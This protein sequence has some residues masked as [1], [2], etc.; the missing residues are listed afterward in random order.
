MVVGREKSLARAVDLVQSGICV[1]IV[2]SRGSGRTTF[3]SALRKRLED[4]EWSV[5]SVRGVASLRQHSLAALHLAGIGS[6]ARS[7][8]VLHETA[9]A[10]RAAVQRENSVVFLDD[11]DDLDESSWGIVESIRRETGVP[12]VLT[13]LQGLR[14]RHTPSGLTAS[15]LEPSYVI[16]M[17]PLRFDDMESALTSYLGG[18]IEAS[19]ISRIF[20]KSGGNIGLAISLVDATTREGLLK[21]RGDRGEWTAARDLWSPGLR[22]VLEGYLENLDAA[23]RDAVE[24]IA[25]VGVAGIESVRQLVD[26]STLELLEERSL[27]AFVSGGPQQLVTVVPPLLVEF[28]R[29]EPLNARRVRLTQL[30][31]DRLGTEESMTA[32]LA[33]QQPVPTLAPEGEAMFVRLLHERARARRIVTASEWHASPSPG[34]AIRYISAL[35]TG[36][37]HTNAANVERVF[38]GT[39]LGG[40][41]P[42]DLVAF[43]ALR[44]RWVAYTHNDH[45]AAL[46]ILRDGRQQHLGRYERLLDATEVEI[47][48]TL[49]AIP[50]GFEERLEVT[51]D[52]P[53][54]VRAALLETQL[55]ILVESARFRDAKRIFRQ[56]QDTDS[57]DPSN[58]AQ[59]LYAFALLGSGRADEALQLLLQGLDEAQGYL[60]IEAI[61]LFG[62]AVTLC[63]AHSGDHASIDDLLET[64]FSAGDPTPIPVGIQLT[65]LGVA[66]LLAARRGHIALSERFADE[67]TQIAAPDG[68]LPGQSRAWATVP[69]ATFNGKP[70]TAA[71]VLWNASV[72][73]WNRGAR[74]A[75]MVGLLNS[76]EIHPTNERFDAARAYLEEIPEAVACRAHFAYVAALREPDAAALLRAALELERV[77]CIG[78]ALAACQQALTSARAGTDDPIAAEATRLDT[79]IRA[80]NEPGSYDSVRFGATS[81]ILSDRES[82]VARLA[83]DGLSNKEIA[84]RLVL[85]VRTVENHM[86]RILRKLEVTSRHELRAH[87]DRFAL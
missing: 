71:T 50:E 86:N 59:V 28:F 33:E 61:Q 82:E 13:R 24:I 68:P 43:T 17:L 75:A 37:T 34:N 2:G 11:W 46:A 63:Y 64:I 8:S 7:G 85:S 25:I 72:E 57:A 80:R 30:T 10:L 56:I 20:A 21:I 60:D 40:S 51:D 55:L 81:T 58:M 16:D 70:E 31:L 47:G 78:L 62:S 19:T 3:L 48:V 69:I 67:A 49:G 87:A 54:T 4:A 41:T 52:L 23:A 74:Y 42:P 29:H 79:D 65:L 77:G 12:I 1:D 44:A 5:I 18:P 36:G 45:A 26:W 83:A 39:E 15:T 35:I 66:A 84:T 53:V 32:M 27:I 73:L 14:A 38:H 22:A 9:T 76:L 6:A